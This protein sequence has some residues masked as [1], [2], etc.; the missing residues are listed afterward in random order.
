MDDLAPKND[1]EGLPRWHA[2]GEPIG[3]V[4]I[5]PSADWVSKASVAPMQLE[6]GSVNGGCIVYGDRPDSAHLPSVDSVFFETMP[7]P[8]KVTASPSR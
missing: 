2:H 1:H 6:S 5:V 8:W 3:K 4:T 7:S